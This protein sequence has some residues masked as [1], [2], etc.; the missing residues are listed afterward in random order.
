MPLLIRLGRD[1]EEVAT[2]DVGHG[3]VF[4]STTRSDLPLNR[5][6]R[7]EMVLPPG[8]TLFEADGKLVHRV[9]TRG[10]SRT[11][12]GIQFYGWGREARQT[13]DSFIA[14]VRDRFPEVETGA[15]RLLRALPVERAHRRRPE[16]ALTLSLIAERLPD[17]VGFF[18]RA[19]TQHL[20][21]ALGAV[22]VSP[23]EEVGLEIVHP[24]TADIFE[25]AARVTRVVR[26]GPVAGL[27]LVLID[28]D[29]ERAARFDEFVY[30]ALAPIF[31]EESFDPG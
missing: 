12:Y 5:L 6:V 13:W 21:F 31:D 27:E 25:L 1:R 10:R 7:I 29:A 11:G 26:D 30:D 9:E 14:F 19:V 28:L 16:Q 2:E 24:H 8:A 15:A 3:G 23:G 17:L 20:V 18:E 22:D 4:V